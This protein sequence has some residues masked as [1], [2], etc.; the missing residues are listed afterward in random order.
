MIGTMRDERLGF[1]LDRCRPQRLSFTQCG[2]LAPPEGLRP[3]VD[4]RVDRLAWY[5]AQPAGF[6]GV[7]QRVPGAW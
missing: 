3:T 6:F 7:A 1:T 2:V 4:K 5:V